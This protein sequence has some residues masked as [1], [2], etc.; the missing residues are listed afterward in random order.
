MDLYS[1]FKYSKILKI[2]FCG[3]LFSTSAKIKPAHDEP[4]YTSK[5]SIVKNQKLK[6]SGWHSV[7]QILLKQR[8]GFH[9]CQLL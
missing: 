4:V 2:I 7:L 6:E 9:T 3:L 8:T 1:A 5:K